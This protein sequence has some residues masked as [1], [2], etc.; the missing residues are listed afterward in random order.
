MFL[1]GLTRAIIVSM[2]TGTAFI[3]ADQ[4]RKTYWRTGIGGGTLLGLSNKMLNIRHFDDLIEM[5]QSGNLANIDLNISD[6]TKDRMETLP[7]EITASISVKSVTW[8]QSRILP[9]A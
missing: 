7:P 2:G 5:A 6:I 1:T 9:W 8:L 4:M 3:I